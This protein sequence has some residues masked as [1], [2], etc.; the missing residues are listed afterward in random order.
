GNY[1]NPFN[2]ETTISYSVKEPGRVR[3]EI[4]NI[5]GQLVRTL[6]DEEH[7]T[8]NYKLSFDGKDNRGRSVASGVYLLRMRAPGYQK[9]AK[10]VLLR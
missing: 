6:V 8:G 4:Y 1:P 10:M 5:K 9:R 3:L 2:P 7:L